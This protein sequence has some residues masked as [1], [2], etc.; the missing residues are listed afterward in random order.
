METY[1]VCAWQ[2]T[3]RGAEKGSREEKGQ[4]GVWEAGVGDTFR[5][6]PMVNG[7]TGPR[8]PHGT[9]QKVA[10]GFST[11]EAAQVFCKCSSRGHGQIHK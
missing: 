6:E 1:L 9:R 4:W 5:K 3:R 10:T 7:A 8:D 2:G 11:R